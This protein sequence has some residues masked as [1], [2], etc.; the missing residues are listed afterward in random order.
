MV[1]CSGCVLGLWCMTRNIRHITANTQ[2]FSGEC[3]RC[4][5]SGI[6]A[7]KSKQASL[8]GAFGRP[9]SVHLAEAHAS[10]KDVVCK[11]EKS[12]RLV[13]CPDCSKDVKRL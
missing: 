12:Q 6:Y 9:V 1:D 2:L 11:P 7:V 3:T 4:K 8:P 13:L 5:K 10:E